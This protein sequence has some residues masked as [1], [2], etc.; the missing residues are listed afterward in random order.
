MFYSQVNRLG[1]W[2]GLAKLLDLWSGISRNEEGTLVRRKKMDQASFASIVTGCTEVN[3]ALNRRSATVTEA[4][5]FGD[6][7]FAVG[8]IGID[9]GDPRLAPNGIP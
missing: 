7:K 9:N 6:W 3:F 2:P 5:Y 8:N 4:P 1:R